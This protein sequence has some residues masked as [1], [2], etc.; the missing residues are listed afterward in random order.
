MKRKTNRQILIGFPLMAALLAP[1]LAWAYIG[2]FTRYW[3]DDFCY[4]SVLHKLGFLRSQAYWYQHWTGRYSFIFSNTTLESIG[5]WLPR[6]LPAVLLLI[7][8]AVGVWTFYQLLSL[9]RL[10]CALISSVLLAELIIF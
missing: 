8:L 6:F 2:L 9:T 7:W 10:P 1:L 5:P 3:F 4:T